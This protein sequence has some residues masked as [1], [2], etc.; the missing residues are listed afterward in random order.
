MLCP[1]V[2]HMGAHTFKVGH[3]F[4]AHDHITRPTEQPA[5]ALQSTKTDPKTTKTHPQITKT[6]PID[7][8][9]YETVNAVPQRETVNAVPQ[10]GAHG[11]HTSKSV[12]QSVAHAQDHMITTSNV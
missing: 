8:I 12:V 7:E 6:P 9:R 10:S 1:K 5:E 2:G 3:T 4:G 11:A